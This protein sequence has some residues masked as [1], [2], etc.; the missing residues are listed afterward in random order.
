MKLKHN[1]GILNILAVIDDD[2]VPEAYQQI[3]YDPI[4]IQFKSG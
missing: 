4:I 3:A 2:N 1:K